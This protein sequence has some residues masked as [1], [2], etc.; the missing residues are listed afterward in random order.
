MGIQNSKKSYWDE[1]VENEEKLKE[2]ILEDPSFDIKELL[3]TKKRIIFLEQ[4]SACEKYFSEKINLN[5]YR[6]SDGTFN[7][8]KVER[9]LNNKY[10][11][12][13]NTMSEVA[14]HEGVGIGNGKNIFFFDYGANNKQ[15]GIRFWDSKENKD[16]W[17]KIKK[18]GK[19]NASDDDV[20]EIFFGKKNEKWMYPNDYSILFH[21]CQDYSKEKINELLNHKI[22]QRN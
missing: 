8:Y 18:V 21:N 6:N 10:G 19:S 7:V 9:P 16:N 22:Y 4:M 14:H 17:G 3:N 5:I 1:R 13:S 2:K 11:N 12:G 15:L 20:K